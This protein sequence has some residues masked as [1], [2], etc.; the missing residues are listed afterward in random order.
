MHHNLQFL[1]IISLEGVLKE[2][3]VFGIHFCFTLMCLKCLYYMRE[4]H[5]KY[6][7]PRLRVIYSEFPNTFQTDENHLNKS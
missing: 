1:K 3:T 7:I 2:V 4:M 5:V 6:D